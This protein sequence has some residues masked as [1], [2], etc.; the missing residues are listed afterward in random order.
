MTKPL[1][2]VDVDGVLCPFGRCAVHS[3]DGHTTN[4]PKVLQVLRE[5]EYPGYT[6]HEGAQVHYSEANIERLARL[7]KSFELVWCTGWEE[8]ANEII[9]PLHKLAKL[10]VVRIF[11]SLGPYLATGPY[12]HW[13]KNAIEEFVGDRAY[14]FIDDDITADGI[15]YANNRWSKQGI[16]T[17]WMRIEPTDGLQE[18]HLEGLEAFAEDAVQSNA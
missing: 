16:P 10:P 18:Y 12:V 13:K 1:L 17:L 14:A 11:G 8:K 2:L 3:F 4:N 6:F 7:G 15:I 9:G 5:A